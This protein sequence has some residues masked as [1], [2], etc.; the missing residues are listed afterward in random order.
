[1]KTVKPAGIYLFNTVTETPKPCLISVLTTKTPEINN[2]VL[3]SVFL[4]LSKF[5]VL[6]P[7]WVWLT[8]RWMGFSQKQSPGDIP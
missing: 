7:C 2:V 3:G 1:M 6:F 5:H 4:T 8:K